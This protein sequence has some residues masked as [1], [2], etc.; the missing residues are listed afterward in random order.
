[1][2]AGDGRTVVGIWKPRELASEDALSLLKLAVRH[3]RG[4][5]MAAVSESVCLCIAK[6]M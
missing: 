3:G 5:G 1:M 4:D 6:K 2:Y